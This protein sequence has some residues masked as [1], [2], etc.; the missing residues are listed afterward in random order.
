MPIRSARETFLT[1]PNKAAFEQIT[2]TA[3]FESACHYALLALVEELPTNPP[4]VSLQNGM[5]MAG[6]RRVLTLLAAM[7]YKDEEPKRSRL[8][9][10][11]PN[12]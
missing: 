2:Q 3:A 12:V 10:L 6:A 8:P 4:E 1:G 5:I 9:Q 7:P 11:N